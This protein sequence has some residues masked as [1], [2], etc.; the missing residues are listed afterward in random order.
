MPNGTLH[1]VKSALLGITTKSQHSVLIDPIRC[2]EGPI[3]A[4][5]IT[6]ALESDAPILT[7]NLSKEKGVSIVENPYL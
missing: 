1:T 2:A 7:F 6:L 4:A 5:D 3:N